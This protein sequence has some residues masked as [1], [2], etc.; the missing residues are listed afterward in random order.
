MLAINM[1]GPRF[2][3]NLFHSVPLRFLTSVRSWVSA[4]VR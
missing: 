2:F 1:A 3:A 4:C